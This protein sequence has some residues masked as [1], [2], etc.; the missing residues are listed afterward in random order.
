M[1]AFG[2][3]RWD[4]SFKKTT[5]VQHYSQCFAFSSV[6]ADLKGPNAYQ[7]YTIIVWAMLSSIFFRSESDL[8]YV[9]LYGGLSV[10]CNSNVLSAAC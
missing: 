10:L 5:N 2:V 1:A 7:P 8:V 4:F 3:T 6:Q 9:G